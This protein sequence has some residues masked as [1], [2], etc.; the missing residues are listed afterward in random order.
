M[1]NHIT[2]KLTVT[3]PESTGIIEACKSEKSEFDFNKILPMPD[4]LQNTTSP[5][6]QND[7]F[8]AKYGYDN[9]YNWSIANWGTKWNCY[10]VHADSNFV[11]FDTAWCTPK[12]LFQALSTMYPEALLTIEYADE[13]IGYNCGVLTYQNGKLLEYI[14]K[15]IGNLDSKEESVRWAM[16]VKYGSDEGYED[17]L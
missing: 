3:G 14:P 11:E 17:Y 4:E 2:N 9:W 1:P 15:D 16:V 10:D 13:D 12:P 7:E 8:I 6:E 5:C